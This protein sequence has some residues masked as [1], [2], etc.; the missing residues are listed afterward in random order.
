MIGTI[1]RITSTVNGQSYIGSTHR[2]VEERW[3]EHYRE[4]E[5]NNHHNFKMAE[6]FLECGDVFGYYVI[7]TLD[8]DEKG[9][10]EL[11]T[12][13]I[14]KYDSVNNGFNLSYGQGSLGVPNPGRAISEES[15]QLLVNL[16]I[17]RI[18]ETKQLA[19]NLGVTQAAVRSVL[20]R[21][22]YKEYKIRIDSYEK[23]LELQQLAEEY[24]FREVGE[25]IKWMHKYLKDNPGITTLPRRIRKIL[26]PEGLTTSYLFGDYAY[27]DMIEYIL[28]RVKRNKELEQQRKSDECKTIL[29]ELLKDN[30]CKRVAKKLGFS[31]KKVGGTKNGAQYAKFHQ[32]LRKRV[33]SLPRAL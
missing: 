29:E 8:I 21:N 6:H 17:F 30:N 33:L 1:Y 28:D 22:T 20:N 24:R 31:E 26:R 4:L 19:K 9:L 15:A 27:Q 32:E 25:K 3:Y 13:Y 18:L 12:N 14:K 10:I 23:Y 11:E 7:E 5:R 2:P 16:S